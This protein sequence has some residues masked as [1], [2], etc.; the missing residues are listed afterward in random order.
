METYLGPLSDA[1]YQK[2]YALQQNFQ[3]TNY[4]EYLKLFPDV[5]E[6]L[7]ILKNA[8]KHLAIVSARRKPTLHI[9]LQATGVYDL[10]EVVVSPEM[11]EGRPKPDPEPAL[12]ALSLMNGTT[13][14]AILIGDTEVDIECGTRA[15]MDTAFVAWSHKPVDAMSIQ[16]TMILT[17]MRELV[18]QF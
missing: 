11:T 7:H 16:P 15:G 13:E 18:S 2:I 6:T 1:D 10:F 9:Y 17:D 8:E 4:R 5:A 12:K 3:L 14:N